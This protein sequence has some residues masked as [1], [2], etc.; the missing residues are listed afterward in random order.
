VE[1]ERV[2]SPP[3]SEVFELIRCAELRGASRSEAA[4]AAPVD[5]GRR[6]APPEPTPAPAPAPSA[7]PALSDLQFPAGIRRV[8]AVLRMALPFVEAVLP[9]LDG[10]TG[11]ALFG[12]SSDVSSA[13]ALPP[14]ADLTLIEDT[15]V[16]LQ[17][18]HTELRDQVIEQNASLLVVEDQLEMVR[19]ATDR[20]TLMQQELTEDLKSVGKKMNVLSMVVLGMLGISTA[21]SF[22]L[23]LHLFRVIR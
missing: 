8:A 14:T 9:L 21:S 12:P 3:N 18:R 19:N 16:K 23:F 1:Y 10:N 6:S 4:P 20:N 11:A 2:D 22:Y 15:L 17:A 5:E 13:A 7:L